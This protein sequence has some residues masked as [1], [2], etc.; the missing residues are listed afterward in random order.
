MSHPPSVALHRKRWALSQ[1]ELA[2][3][4]ATSQAN[5]SRIEEGEADRSIRL[6]VALG[7]QVVFGR[8][9][10]SLFAALFDMI[11]EEVMTRAA[12]LEV[13]LRDLHDAESLKKK[14]LLAQMLKRATSLRK[15]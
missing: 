2:T 14:Q 12:D 9:P 13:N 7:L 6:E 15:L 3:L 4:L 11:E 5:V 10:R 8:G 1:D